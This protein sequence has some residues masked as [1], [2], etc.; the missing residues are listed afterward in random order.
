MTLDIARTIDGMERAWERVAAHRAPLLAEGSPWRF[1]RETRQ[2][3]PSQ[4]WKLHLSADVTGAATLLNALAPVFDTERDL[5]FKVPSSLLELRRLN[6]GLIGGYSQVGKCVT[7]Y[8]GSAEEAVR[9]AR[10]IHDCTRGLSGPTVPFERRF[11]DGIVFYRFGS[12]VASTIRDPE[13]E[14]IEDSRVANPAWVGDPFLDGAGEKSRDDLGLVRVFDVLSQRGKGGVYL[15]LDFA[16]IPARICVIKEG[17]PRGEM[18]WDGRD[19]RWRVQHDASVLRELHRSGVRTPRVLREITTRGHRYVLLERVEGLT[20]EGYAARYVRRPRRWRRALPIAVRLARLVESVHRAGWA[21]RD[22]KPANVLIDRNGCAHALD[23]EGACPLDA[24]DPW[25]WGSPVYTPRSALAGHERAQ[26]AAQD[27]FGLGR[28]IVHL[29]NA[30]LPVFEGLGP[31]A[32][33]LPSPIAD[34]LRRLHAADPSCR[35]PAAEVAA[36]LEQCV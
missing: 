4:G 19:G 6:S 13:G 2:D 32:P 16:A 17:R 20:V 12:F 18:E 5:L 1:S 3:D 23:F 35:P 7:V 31:V 15:A 10:K 22:V 25:P 36:T 34:V 33:M 28:S 29:F 21:W 24:P 9:V 8:P 26:P 27:L 30:T 14:A 11:R